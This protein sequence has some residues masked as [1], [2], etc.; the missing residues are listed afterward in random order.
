MAAAVAAVL[1]LTVTHNPPGVNDSPLVDT[2]TTRPIVLHVDAFADGC[3]T[4]PALSRDARTAAVCVPPSAVPLSE[5][6][7]RST[8]TTTVVLD[9]SYTECLPNTFSS[10]AYEWPQ[11]EALG[12][13][14]VL[15]PKPVGRSRRRH[16]RRRSVRHEARGA[17]EDGEASWSAVLVAVV[18]AVLATLDPVTAWACV[19]AATGIGMLLADWHFWWPVCLTL[20]LNY[21]VAAAW[22]TLTVSSDIGVVLASVAVGMRGSG[23]LF[24]DPCSSS[25][26]DQQGQVAEKI[27]CLVGQGYPIP[28]KYT[29]GKGTYVNIKKICSDPQLFSRDLAVYLS[30]FPDKKNQRPETP[31]MDKYML[32]SAGDVNVDVATANCG[33]YKIRFNAKN[34]KGELSEKFKDDSQ[35]YVFSPSYKRHDSALLYDRDV[36]GITFVVVS[37]EEVELY[38]NYLCVPNL[39]LLVLPTGTE[40]IGAT[41][42]A[43]LDFAYDLKFKRIWMLDD[44]I[45]PDGCKQIISKGPPARKRGY[46]FPIF[47]LEL[48]NFKRRKILP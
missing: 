16:G 10:P 8:Q 47:S 24:M 13:T 44:N 34:L 17:E 2:A 7:L 42:Y 41:R 43:I 5:P 22:I 4:T 32:K 28:D 18:L 45:N 31:G 21:W 39:Y 30:K 29:C 20:S 37:E 11:F 27:K 15:Q 3:S 14:H 12:V 1:L 40:T 6:S 23:W 25:A 48:R 26:D 46:R 33:E 35:R 38:S 19:T 36:G 9:T